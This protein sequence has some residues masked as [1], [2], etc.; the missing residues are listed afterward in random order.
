[1]T[2]RLRLT[3][4]LALALLMTACGDATDPGTNGNGDG[5]GD[6]VPTEAATGEEV[7]IAGLAFGQQAI[8]VS[9]GTTVTWANNDNV[10]HTVTHGE[11]GQAAADAVIDEPIGVG[12]EVSFTFDEAGTYPITCTVHPQMNMV[13][14]VE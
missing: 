3:G 4:A 12:E 6:A 11:D 14:E 9:A 2:T 1:M 5:D 13:V 8:T 10:G 7:E